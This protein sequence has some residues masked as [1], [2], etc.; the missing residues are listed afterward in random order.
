MLVLVLGVGVE[1]KLGQWLARLAHDNPLFPRVWHGL[2]APLLRSAVMVGAVLCAYPALFGFR[3]AP[4]LGTLFPSEAARGGT[5]LGLV[6]LFRLLAPRLSPVRLR[7]ATLDAAQSLCAVA[8]V[9]VWY[10]D[11]LGAVS[12]SAWPGWLSALALCGLCTLLPPLAAGL[13][14]DFGTRLDLHFNLHG[15]D[16]YFAQGAAMLAVAPIT[17]LYGY[18]LGTQLGM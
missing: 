12:A 8:V 7:P 4:A 1:L 16:E 18:L 2:Y 10:A 6:F 9:F 5:L 11:Y 3:A 15:L 13:G 14:R 17:M